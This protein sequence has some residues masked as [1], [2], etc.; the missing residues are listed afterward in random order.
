MELVE[1]LE[2]EIDRWGDKLDD[3]FPLVHAVDGKGKELMT[4]A[5]AYREDSKYFREKGD[6]VRSYECLIWA[7]AIVEVGRSVGRIMSQSQKD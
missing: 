5:R 1:Q 6:L 3:L 2:Q 4:N 7:W